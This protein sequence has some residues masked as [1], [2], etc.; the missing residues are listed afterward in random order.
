[1]WS[2][3]FFLLTWRPGHIPLAPGPSSCVELCAAVL[4]HCCC[5]LCPWGHRGSQ[6]APS[7]CRQLVSAV[8]CPTLPGVGVEQPQD[9][10]QSHSDKPR[11]GKLQTLISPSGSQ[12]VT[13]PPFLGMWAL[14]PSL[15]CHSS[16]CDPEH[17]RERLLGLGPHPAQE[18]LVRAVGDGGMDVQG[19]CNSC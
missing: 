16:L 17:H 3:H 5:Q 1:M 4:G 14:L 10:T 2:H 18:Q 15:G 12:A 7:S 9:T 6:A 19:G 11:A 8:P 13:F